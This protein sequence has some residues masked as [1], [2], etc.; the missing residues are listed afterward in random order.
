MNM[1]MALSLGARRGIIKRAQT[2][3]RVV[4]AY[5]R[6]LGGWCHSVPNPRIWERDSEGQEKG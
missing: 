3:A 6:L 4:A 1:S 2:S 5:A